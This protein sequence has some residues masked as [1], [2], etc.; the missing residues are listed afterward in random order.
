MRKLSALTLATTLVLLFSAC[1]GTFREWK[2]TRHYVDTDRYTLSVKGHRLENDEHLPEATNQ[3][4]GDTVRI[5]DDVDIVAYQLKLL[6]MGLYSTNEIVLRKGDYVLSLE[7]INKPGSND[8]DNAQAALRHLQEWGYIKADT[9][10]NQKVAVVRQGSSPA[11]YDSTAF[12]GTTYYNIEIPKVLLIDSVDGTTLG[13]WVDGWMEARF[14]TDNH[15]FKFFAAHGYD[16]VH[17]APQDTLIY[18]SAQRKYKHS[19]PSLIVK[20]LKRTI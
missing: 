18:Y 9:T 17:T 16:T 3:L 12:F 1:S 8:A 15:L 2:D 5:Y 7:L 4:D 10:A 19:W 13:E 20:K 11:D 14:E 6:S